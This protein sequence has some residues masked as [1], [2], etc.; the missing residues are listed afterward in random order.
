[1]FGWSTSAGIK[2]AQPFGWWAAAVRLACYGDNTL[3]FP[4]DGPSLAL[5]LPA[6]LLALRRSRRPTAPSAPSAPLSS[7]TPYRALRPQR[8]SLLA[9]ALP[10]APRASLPRRCR[11]PPFVGVAEVKEEDTA[12]DRLQTA[13]RRSGLPSSCTVLPAVHC[14]RICL[15]RSDPRS[16]NVVRAST[17]SVAPTSPQIRPL[18]QLPSPRRSP[19][20]E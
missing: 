13:T 16:V 11:I 8:A 10:R 15:R 9:D 7:P 6:P 18:T 12:V 17:F 3:G 2:K 1:V 20:R 5:P 4:A 19:L 14:F